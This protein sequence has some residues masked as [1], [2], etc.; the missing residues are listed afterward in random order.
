MTV[1][2]SSILYQFTNDASHLINRVKEQICGELEKIDKLEQM[3][4]EMKKPSFQ[5]TT[6]RVKEAVSKNK[7][8]AAP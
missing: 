8:F 4:S 6:E 7:F 3:V 2:C 5:E 1:R